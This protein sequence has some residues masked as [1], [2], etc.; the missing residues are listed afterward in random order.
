MS[1]ATVQNALAFG[2]SPATF[3]EM[4]LR[5]VVE[6]RGS[7]YAVAGETTPECVSTVRILNRG[8]TTQIRGLRD[9]LLS[10]SV[11]NCLVPTMG[12]SDEARQR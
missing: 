3:R 12:A 9:L 10:D 4:N 5:N 11:I 1:I 6:T 8:N 2:V 7:Q